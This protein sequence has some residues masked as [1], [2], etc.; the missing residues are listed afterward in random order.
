M[1]VALMLMLYS[2]A[3]HVGVSQLLPT[4]LPRT[5]TVPPLIQKCQANDQFPFLESLPNGGQCILSLGTIDGSA[6]TTPFQVAD[7]LVNVCNDDCGGIYSKFLESPCND[8]TAAE[9]IR[10]TCTPTNGSAAVGDV[11]HYALPMIMDSQLLT[12][13]SSCDNVTSDL[14]CTSSCREALMKLKAQIGCCFQNVYN[15]TI[16][17]I[18]QFR[19]NGF[20]TQNELDSLRMLTNPDTNPW[21]ICEIEPPEI[22]GAPLFKPPPPPQCTPDDLTDFLSSLPNAAVCGPSI[23]NVLTLPTN[24]S[25][26]LAKVLDNVCTNDCGGVYSDFLKSTCNDQ[27]QAETLR[28]WCVRTNGNATA[29]PYCRFAVEASLSNELSMCD[30]SSSC[31]PG[32]R[33]A[34]LQFTDQIGCCYQDLFNNTFYYRQ[35]VLNKIITAREFTKFTQINN[36]VIGPWT[37]CGVPVPSKCPEQPPP[38]G[39]C[40]VGILCS[41][42]VEIM[43]IKQFGQHAALPFYLGM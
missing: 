23:A 25:T 3:V 4:V 30:S 29:G 8:P 21:M 34:L 16:Y 5:E 13:F 41:S 27:F 37:L 38:D 11:C 32:C 43:Q 39:K 19:N 2:T 10:I 1:R 31:S 6:V 40:T 9:F 12:E 14:P 15:N 7:A 20:L 33:S 36:P 26:E 28:I 35:Q 17:D 24:D 42:Y 22:C 18:Q